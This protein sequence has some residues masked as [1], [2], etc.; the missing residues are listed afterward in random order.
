MEVWKYTIGTRV[1]TDTLVD[2][3]IPKGAQILHTQSQREIPCIWA[4]VNPDA[5]LETRYFYTAATGEEIPDSHKYI[6]TVTQYNGEYMWHIFEV[7]A[8]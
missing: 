6:G 8:C 4:L 3:T 1:V 7:V 2:I 5:E